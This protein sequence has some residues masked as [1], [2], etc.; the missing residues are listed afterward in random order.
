M[1]LIQDENSVRQPQKAVFPGKY[2]QGKN[3][4]TELKFLTESF[5]NKGLLLASPSV[6]T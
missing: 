4:L 5:G 3:A 1:I 6:I 2:I